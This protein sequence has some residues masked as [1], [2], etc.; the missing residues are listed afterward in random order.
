MALRTLFAVLVALVLAAPSQAG[1]V[2]T[3]TSTQMTTDPNTQTDPAISGDIVMWTDDRN[4]NDDVYFLD[5]TTFVETQVTSNP[6]DQELGD[7]SGGWIV[8]TDTQVAVD[9]IVAYDIASGA[10]TVVTSGGQGNATIDGDLVVYQDFSLVIGGNRIEEIHLADLGAGTT[11]QLTSTAVDE[12]N[13]AIGGGYAVFEREAGGAWDVILHDLVSGVETNLGPGAHP[14]TDGATVVWNAD[15]GAG[16]Q[17]LFFYDIGSGNTTHLVQAGMQTRPHVDGDIVCYDD[18]AAGNAD[19]VVRHIPSGA[20]A[21]VG[22]ASI[23]FLNDCD[24]NRVAY[25]S[26]DTNFD[27][28]VYEFAVQHGDIG[29]APSAVDFGDVVLGDS[30]AMIVT[31]TNEG[32][33]SLQ[34]TGVSLLDGSGPISLDSVTV[35]GLPAAPPFT[36]AP[37][38]TADVTLGFSPGAEALFADTLRVTSDDFDEPST[39]VPVSGVGVVVDEPPA[40][41]IAG[42]LDAIDAA[43]A[44][45]TL[46][47]SG[48]GK[49]AAGRLGALINKIE[50]AGDAL[51][52]GLEGNACDQLASAQSRVDGVE[53]PPDF[54][55]GA[56]LGSVFSCLEDARDALDC[57]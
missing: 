57:D 39:D 44:A 42:C 28:W 18:N 36:L 26:F 27:I 13:P 43:V 23:G 11:T 17:D 41:I 38:E 22:G 4:G 29:V 52:D 56:A 37:A 16:D 54:A 2:I 34:V 31:I 40:E 3:G 1:V 25:T 8:Y 21:T 9:G 20:T 7:V 32:Q 45:G 55:A 24:G 51:A 15:S 12:R 49:S 48:P 33:Q 53:P 46:A 19:V 35:G 47:G 6:A 50:A 10:S 5:L 30:S 14:H